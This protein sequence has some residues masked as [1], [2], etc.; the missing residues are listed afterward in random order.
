[1]TRSIL[2]LGA[3]ALAISFAT[4]APAAA[5]MFDFTYAGGRDMISGSFTTASKITSLSGNGV[6]TVF[7]ITAIDGAIDGSAITSLLPTNTAPFAN[8]NAYYKKFASLDFTGVAFSDAA[9]QSFDLFVD[10]SF[11][12]SEAGLSVASGQTAIFLSSGSLTITPAS[13]SPVPEPGSL[14]LL[15]T[16]LIGLSVAMRGRRS[17]RD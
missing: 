8:D 10:G 6:G 17:R 9:G 12:A 7:S 14:V 11:P 2:Y 15:G 16:G 5:S 1:M 13:P 3:A 4:I